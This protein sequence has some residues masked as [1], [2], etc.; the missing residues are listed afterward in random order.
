MIGLGMVWA[1]LG[2]RSIMVIV[3]V[4]LALYGRSG[5]L[6]SR[7]ARAILPWLT[8]TR[9]PPGGSAAG[10]S[11]GSGPGSTSKPGPA[12]GIG[13]RGDRTFWFLTILAASALAAWIVTRTIILSPPV[14]SH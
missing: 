4:V 10:S 9:R 1:M 11:S 2:P 5:V 14:V 13:L 7:Q 3:M 6:R 12:A 8:P